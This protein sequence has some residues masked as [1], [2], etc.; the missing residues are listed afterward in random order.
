MV[1]DPATRENLDFIL[2]VGGWDSSN[3]AHLVEIPHKFGIAAYHIN[4][5]ECI[6]ADNSI[7]YRDVDG[8]IKTKENFLPLGRPAVVG[9][10]SGASTPDAYVQ[11]SLEQ[12][13]LLK[14][15]S[16]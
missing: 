13:Y 1:E 8:E 12:L 14:G 10:T 16:C 4:K 9:V 6:K 5:A 7:T 11:E 15:L 2:V 3:T